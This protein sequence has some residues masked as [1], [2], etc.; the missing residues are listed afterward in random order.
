M[1]NKIDLSNFH[2]SIITKPT[3]VRVNEENIELEAGYNP[4][5]DGGDYMNK[6]QLAYFKKMLLHWKAGLVEKANKTMKEL[7]SESNNYTAEEGEIS[8]ISEE[9]YNEL[10]MCDR[11]RKLIAKIDAALL[12]IETGDYGYCEKS[13]EEIGIGRLC[14]RPI[15]RLCIAM[16]E[17]HEK[18]EDVKQ[19][20]EYTHAILANEDYD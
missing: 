10:R 11:Q 15:A 1:P 13:G 17:I 18:E 2:S 4:L 9:H 8:S 12:S 3:A 16:Q 19:D 7:T 5:N 6:K 20:A 14:A